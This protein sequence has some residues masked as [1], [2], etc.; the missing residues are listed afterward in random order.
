MS[1]DQHGSVR[2]CFQLFSQG[3]HKDPQGCHVVLPGRAPELPGDIFMRQ[4]LAAVPGQQAQQLI[5]D[6]RQVQ[7]LL[8]QIRAAGG[9]IDFQAAVDEYGVVL[10]VRFC[11]I[12]AAERNPQPCF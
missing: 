9:E 7:L 8:P 11:L 3:S 5:L 4:Y 6:G 2:R 10:T 1:L 12:Q